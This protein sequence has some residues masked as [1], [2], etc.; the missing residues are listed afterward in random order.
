MVGV[1]CCSRANRAGLA[2]RAI[3]VDPCSDQQGVE[4]VRALLN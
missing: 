1:G 2:L 4:L 3:R